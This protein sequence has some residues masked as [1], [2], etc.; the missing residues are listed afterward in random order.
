[1]KAITHKVTHYYQPTNSTCGYAALAIFLSFYGIDKKPE[2]LVVEVPQP[3][4]EKGNAEGSVTAQLV[5]WCQQNDLKVQM[6]AADCMILDLSWQKLDEAKI[7]E[8]LK[9]VRLERNVLGLGKHWSKV[10]V[11][12]YLAMLESG[13]KLKVVSFITS[14]LLYKLLKNGPVYA[15]I[16][17]TALR[18]QGRKI[19]TGLR[20][21]KLDDVHGRVSNH[22]LVI[23]GHDN[24]G[25]FLLADPWDGRIVVEPEKMVLAIE[26][27]QIECDNQ[28]FVIEQ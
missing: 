7:A 16:C 18:G 2:E 6:Y 3:K 25:N 28:C 23:Y 19:N 11:D 13:A 12:A 21:Q 14:D 4:D 26:A 20:K 17:S 24:K 5:T 15:N 27:A 9:A 22:S 1:M 8:R 10:Y